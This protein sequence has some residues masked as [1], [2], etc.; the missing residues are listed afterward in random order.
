MVFFYIGVGLFF[1]LSQLFGHIDKFMRIIFGSTFILL[2]L[3][4]AFRT[5]EKA[6]EVFFSDNDID[7]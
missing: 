3:A 1:I 7:D 2:G 4:R 6:R 5:Y